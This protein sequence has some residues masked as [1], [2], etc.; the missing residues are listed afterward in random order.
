MTNLTS[1]T[2]K[3]TIIFLMFSLNLFVNIE[4]LRLE[5][6]SGSTRC[7]SEEIKRNAMTV[8]T[9]NVISPIEDQPL[10]PSHRIAARVTSPRG[11]DYH[12]KDGVESGNFSFTAGDTGNYMTCFW[13]PKHYPI[14]KISIE[15][16]WKTGIN[17]RDWH[18]IAQKGHIDF[19]SK[20][21][22][23]TI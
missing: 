9:Y 13:A 2:T 20:R 21:L 8:G 14:T 4:S 17:T 3:T 1:I 15:F 18:N 19:N 11:N 23:S 16:E 12:Y 10:P 5:I 22:I 6:E 7:I